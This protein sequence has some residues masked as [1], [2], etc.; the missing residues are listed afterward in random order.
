MKASHQESSADWKDKSSILFPKLPLSRCSSLLNWFSTCW[1]HCF[2]AS[3]YYITTAISLNYH[4]SRNNFSSWTQIFK[5]FVLDA[6]TIILAFPSYFLF[7]LHLLN[8]FKFALIF[9]NL[10]HSSRQHFSGISWM[11][12]RTSTILFP[13]AHKMLYNYYL[14]YRIDNLNIDE[15]D[16]DHRQKSNQIFKLHHCTNFNCSSRPKLQ[17]SRNKN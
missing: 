13:S 17:I 15:V 1:S 3:F 12:R 4:C 5:L 11:L 10:R 7:P 14:Q 2:P 9:L 8:L 6:Y 16:F